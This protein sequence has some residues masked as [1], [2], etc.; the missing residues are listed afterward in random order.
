MEKEF[1]EQNNSKLEAALKAAL[2]PAAAPYLLGRAGKKPH[3]L[4]GLTL[5]PEAIILTA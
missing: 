2:G 4:R 5:P 1:F 3:L